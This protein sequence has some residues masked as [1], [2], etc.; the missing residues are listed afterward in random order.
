MESISLA[1]GCCSSRSRP[2]PLLRRHHAVNLPMHFAREI[3]STAAHLLLLFDVVVDILLGF[4]A[5][6]VYAMEAAA[7]IVP[8]FGLASELPAVSATLDTRLHALLHICKK[9]GS[10]LYNPRLFTCIFTTYHHTTSGDNQSPLFA[11]SRAAAWFAFSA[12]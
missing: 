10:D 9:S 2:E 7:V 4:G 6:C 11:R 8:S 3:S 5:Q 1:R 12:P